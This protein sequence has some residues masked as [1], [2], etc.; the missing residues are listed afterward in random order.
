[1]KKASKHTIELKVNPQDDLDEKMYKHPYLVFQA[2]TVE[3]LVLWTRQLNE[4]ITKTHKNM[5]AKFSMT[6]IMLYGDARNKWDS[7]FKKCTA[8]HPVNKKGLQGAGPLENDTTYTQFLSLFK[9]SW[10]TPAS[11]ALTVQHDYMQHSIRYHTKG[12]Y[13]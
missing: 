3:D 7:L 2:V 6:K 8:R 10:F 11:R 1:M 4:V 13:H 12:V 5:T 9:R